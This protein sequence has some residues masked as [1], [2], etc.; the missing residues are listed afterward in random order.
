[1]DFSLK[2]ADFDY[3]YGKGVGNVGDASDT[4]HVVIVTAWPWEQYMMDIYGSAECA[5][6][7][8]SYL[9]TYG[10]N[11]VRTVISRVVGESHLVNM[12][13]RIVGRDAVE[14]SYEDTVWTLCAS[15]VYGY[16]GGGPV[17]GFNPDDTLPFEVF[18]TNTNVR[19]G[20]F[21]PTASAQAFWL[22]NFSAN[23]MSSWTQSVDGQ[24][25]EQ[26]TQETSEYAVAFL[27]KG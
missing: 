20:R 8:D 7:T 19:R 22:T 16:Y 10:L 17:G 13:K 6:Y 26:Y 11:E 23:S 5:Q 3:Y 4:H 12:R 25:F 1:M 14:L 27:L 21:S 2:I 9:Y 24:I 15:N 18:A